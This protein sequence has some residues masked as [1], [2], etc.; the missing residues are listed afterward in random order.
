MAALHEQ[1]V[2]VAAF[3]EWRRAYPRVFAFQQATQPATA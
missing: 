3:G 1:F 2:V